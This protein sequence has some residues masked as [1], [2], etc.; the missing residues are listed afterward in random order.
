MKFVIVYYL[1]GLVLLILPI[2]EGQSNE[3]EPDLDRLFASV[4][5]NR[6]IVPHILPSL[7][8]EI[9]TVIYNPG[10]FIITGKPYFPYQL[11]SLPEVLWNY[12]DGKY[13]TLVMLGAIQKCN[14]TE[15]WSSSSSGKNDSSIGLPEQWWFEWVKVDIYQDRLNRAGVDLQPFLNTTL[16]PNST[17]RIIYTFAVYEQREKFRFKLDD[18]DNSPEKIIQRHF[19]PLS[20]FEKTFQECALSAGNYFYVLPKRIVLDTSKVRT[21]EWTSS[22]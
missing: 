18:K 15:S 21:F 2:V 7:P 22:I 6:L 17:H 10:L 11:Q 9:C 5:E 8:K 12:R 13:H 20:N 16:Q 14:E 1:Y 3:N 4:F 19:T